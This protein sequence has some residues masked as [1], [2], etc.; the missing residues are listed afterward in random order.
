MPP[1]ANPHEVPG[2]FATT[3]WSVVRRAGSGAGGEA[4]IALERLCQSYWYPLYCCVRRHGYQPSDA[5]DV[6]QSFFEKLLRNNAIE[7]A[8]PERG[9]FR[10][11]LL[12]SL[13]RFL[14]NRHRDA[15]AQKRGG[16]NVVSWDAQT[17]E[18]RYASDPSDGLSPERL[19]EKQ[20]AAAT[21]Y[22]V[23]EKLRCEFADGGKSE[24]FDELEPHLW[25]DET[26]TPYALLSERLQMTVVA[27]RVTVHRLK[28][29]F[30]ELLRSEVA[31]TL[32]S[33][34]LLED[35]LSHLTRSLSGG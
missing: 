15:T 21:V 12:R 10:T 16:G 22:A 31:E 14:H 7:D 3:R 20:W 28:K 24:L 19:F 8:D 4:R 27:L 30:L 32:E 17:A 18:E 2:V 13:E 33:Q 35:E 25:G 26:S 6:T 34:D 29:R 23:M 9:R 11:Y 5:Q 1:P